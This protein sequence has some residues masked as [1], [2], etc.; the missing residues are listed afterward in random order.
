M[1]PEEVP[2]A[3][4][5]RKSG[6][7]TG[8]QCLHCRNTLQQ[9]WPFTPW[10]SMVQEARSSE[11]KRDEFMKAL[12]VVEKGTKKDFVAGEYSW[13]ESSEYVVERE[14]KFYSHSQF[15]ATYSHDP[16]L[17]NLPVD[18]LHDE[19]GQRMTGYLVTMD[20]EPLKVKMRHRVTGGLL[21]LL[22]PRADQI[23]GN[24]AKE[25]K[26]VHESDAIKMRPRTLQ[27]PAKGLVHSTL[28]QRLADAKREKEEQAEKEKHLAEL[29]P[30]LAEGAGDM[31]PPGLPGDTKEEKE[32]DGDSEELEIEQ[33]TSAKPLLQSELAKMGKQKRKSS[34]RKPANA[35]KKGPAHAGA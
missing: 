17:L 11:A 33:D 29:V 20:T 32:S 35:A 15:V 5:L 9:G 27:C 16:S 31:L 18:V 6:S 10:E 24:Q 28:A 4:K 1:C 14:L 23:R 26:D 21:S 19:R 3:A 8:N 25:F 12:S 30:A 34:S 22:Q 13:S 7:F 2:W